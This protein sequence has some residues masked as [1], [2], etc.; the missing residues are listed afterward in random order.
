[1]TVS[2]QNRSHW[3]SG[4]E[5]DLKTF[6]CSML[7]ENLM[8]SSGCPFVLANMKGLH[9]AGG[10]GGGGGAREVRGGTNATSSPI[11]KLSYNNIH[12]MHHA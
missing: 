2:A 12:L 6:E 9:E 1:M 7:S 5:A 10:G 3:C 11:A 8:G 4:R